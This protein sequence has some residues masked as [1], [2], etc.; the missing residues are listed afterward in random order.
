LIEGG[1]VGSDAIGRVILLPDGETVHNAFF[2]R[3]GIDAFQALMLAQQLAR[4]L[5]TTFVERGG[6]LLDGP[7]GHTVSIQDLF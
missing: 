6:V 2:D 3:M 5:L 1:V 4:T 7:G